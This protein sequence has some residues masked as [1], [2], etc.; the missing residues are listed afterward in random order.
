MGPRRSDL[1][2]LATVHGEE[3]EVSNDILRGLPKG[4]VLTLSRLRVR[5]QLAPLSGQSWGTKTS[6]EATASKVKDAKVGE[7]KELEVGKSKEAEAIGYE[8][9]P[10]YD[11]PSMLPP[12]DVKTPVGMFVWVLT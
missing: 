3:I 9:P 11:G 1:V 10:A 8:D 6:E 5:E 4:T 12:A 2:L 7:S